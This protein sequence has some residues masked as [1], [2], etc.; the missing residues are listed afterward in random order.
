MGLMGPLDAAGGRAA[1]QTAPRAHPLGALKG[2]QNSSI[3]LDQAGY[4]AIPRVHCEPL[5][6]TFPAPYSSRVDYMHRPGFERR[7]SPRRERRHIRSSRGIRHASARL[8]NFEHDHI[9]NV[10]D[11]PKRTRGHDG[12]MLEELKA[13]IDRLD[14]VKA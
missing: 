14:A 6:R 2:G 11:A 5:N 1:C 4:G 10:K 13:V 8:D 7:G 3:A 9:K 12:T